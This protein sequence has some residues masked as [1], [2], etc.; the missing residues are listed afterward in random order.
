M[1]PGDPSRPGPSRSGTSDAPPP[2]L[3]ETDPNQDLGAALH[4]VSN[5]LTVLL[6]W[7]DAARTL[8]DPAAVAAALDIVASRASH[9]RDIARRAIGGAP[10]QPAPSAVGEV[11]ADAAVGLSVEAKRA[12][13]TLA[14]HVEPDVA[15]LLVA[16]GDAVIQVLT[17]L[18]LNAISFSPPGSAV[19]LHASVTA[20]THVLVCVDD[21]G[22]GIPPERRERLFEAGVSSRRGGAGIGLRH[23]AALAQ[24]A[25]GELRLGD[26][27]RGTR[28]ELL[29]PLT[30]DPV[31]APAAP[32]PR[33]DRAA[34]DRLS[35][36]GARILVVEDDDAVIQLLE[37]ALEAR[38]ASVVSVKLRADLPRALATGRFDAALLDMSPL[39]GDVDGAVAE[40][41]HAS[42]DARLVVMSG[43]V[44]QVAIG[45]AAV[46]VRK[47][48]EVREIVDAL[49]TPPPPVPLIV[50]EAL[51]APSPPSP[52]APQTAPTKPGKNPNREGMC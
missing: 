50:P 1:P 25:G 12:R 31:E 10:A 32:A 46:W 27:V 52:P 38:G 8:T 17:N 5:A 20:T 3:A 45:S 49:R 34:I 19:H 14:V 43:S 35:I 23:S 40:L 29:W 42:P 51:A 48:F 22:P 2:S 36:D 26:A 30:T 18:L 15:A 13:V 41:R 21:E 47:P 24:Q 44:P 33:A 7:A 16:S 6:G 11:V 39:L 4:E 9:A 37:L 28:F